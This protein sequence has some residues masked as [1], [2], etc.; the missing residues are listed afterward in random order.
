M[1]EAW[2]PL[3]RIEAPPL[4][5]ADVAL[6]MREHRC[7]REE[8]IKVLTANMGVAEYWQNS[9]F[10]VVKY[11][12]GSGW[13]RLRIEGRDGQ[14]VHRDW[15]LFQQVKNQ[16][17]GPECEALELYPADSRKVDEANLYHIYG[18]ADPK[19][20]FSFGMTPTDIGGRAIDVSKGRSKPASYK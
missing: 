5:E 19:V 13:F 4:A 16:L 10:V 3:E 9:A 6:L 1:T 18:V 2:E 15:R 12:L 14:P 17:L 20:R 11:R 8:A 7:S